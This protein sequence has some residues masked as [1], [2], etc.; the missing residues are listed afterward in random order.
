MCI[1]DSL[2]CRANE[3]QCMLNKCTVCHY[4]VQVLLQTDCDLSQQTKWKKCA[5]GLLQVAEEVNSTLKDLVCEI[6]SCLRK[7]KVHVFVK[8]E[9]ALYFEEKKKSLEVGDAVMQVDYAENYSLITQD[10]VKSTHWHHA[11]AAIFT[12]CIWLKNSTFSYAIV[13]DDLTHSKQ[14]AWTFLQTIIFDFK[15][16]QPDSKIQNLFIFSDNCSSQFKSRYTAFNMCYLASDLMVEHVEWNYF[17]AGHG[18]G[19]VDAIGGQVKRMVWTAVKAR[20]VS[21]SSPDEFY[22]VAKDLS[23]IHI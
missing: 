5:N 12:C 15:Q 2:C 21:T 14:S 17:A 11:Q 16:K 22:L 13:S 7:F 18:K 10:E 1:R 3:E 19:A 4:D 9:Q 6:N 8:N 23:L 20:S